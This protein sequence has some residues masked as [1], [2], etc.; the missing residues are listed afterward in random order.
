[1]H[2][3]GDGNSNSDLRVSHVTD[4]SGE[5][6]HANKRVKD[7]KYDPRCLIRENSKRHLIRATLAGNTKMYEKK[8]P[9]GGCVAPKPDLS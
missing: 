4:K 1:M 7:N 2:S 9:R 5:T 8:V 6:L 3:D